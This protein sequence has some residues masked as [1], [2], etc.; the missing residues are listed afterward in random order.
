[1]GAILAEALPALRA[2][3]VASVRESA[4]SAAAIL[5][6]MAATPREGSEPVAR[7]LREVAAQTA[8][9]TEHRLLAPAPEAT[10]RDDLRTHL[11]RLARDGEYL[12]ALPE[13][14]VEAPAL[15]AALSA[16]AT[17]ARSVS[18][19]LEARQLLNAAYTAQQPSPLVAYIQLPIQVGD[20]QHMAE[21]K[22]LRDPRQGAREIDPANATVAIRLDTKT[23]GLVV[24][25]LRTDEKT[26]HV[27][28]TLER[29]EYERAVAREAGSLQAGLERA[30][31]RVGSLATEVRARS[32]E[33]FDRLGP[34]L[35]EGSTLSLLA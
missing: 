29:S 21:L 27:T 20:H 24:A 15:V 25:V 14:E 5:A 17:A 34:S 8:V 11:M 30:G 6:R 12:A 13:A 31:F 18:G 16:L 35:P 19:L 9:S 10:V 2:S 7:A 33:V 23:L 4:S 22:L 1:M 26:V 32:G 3:L 28:F